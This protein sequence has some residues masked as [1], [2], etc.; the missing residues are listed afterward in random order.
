VPSVR[1]GRNKHTFWEVAKNLSYHF[2]VIDRKEETASF[3]RISNS[4]SVSRQLD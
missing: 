3:W 4:F 1:R 2:I